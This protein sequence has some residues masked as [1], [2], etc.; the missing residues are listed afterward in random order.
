M[1][2]SSG[3]VSC[4]GWYLC[5][6]NFI[7]G[8]FLRIFFEAGVLEVAIVPEGI[9]P[10][11][12]KGFRITVETHI[13]WFVLALVCNYLSIAGLERSS[14]LSWM[15]LNAAGNVVLKAYNFPTLYSQYRSMLGYVQGFLRCA[16]KVKSCL[17]FQA[18]V[19][20]PYT[21]IMKRLGSCI[22]KCSQSV[23]A[24]ECLPWRDWG[25]K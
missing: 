23:L 5:G 13:S 12:L 10:S 15:L 17:S 16:L 11:F 8:E 4:V 6:C 1:C 21:T 2:G 19:K 20:L 18:R 3:L 14:K 9:M 24:F 25:A 7:S 22:T